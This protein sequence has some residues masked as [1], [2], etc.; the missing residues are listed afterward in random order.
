MITPLKHIYLSWRKGRSSR[1]Y[2]VG[3][4][5]GIAEGLAR[6]NYTKSGVEEAKKDGFV[7]YTEFSDLDKTYDRDVI[8]VFAQ[9]LT[10][11]T[12]LSLS[13]T[14]RFWLV[15]PDKAQSDWFILAYTQGLLSTDN[16][17]FLADF[18]PFSGL[19]FVT[20]L[21]GLSHIH[22]PVDLLKIGDTLTWEFDSSNEYD[23]KAVAIYYS[24]EKVGYIKK[25]HCNLFHSWP[26]DKIRLSVHAIEKNGVVKNVFAKVTLL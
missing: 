3:E 19:I 11:P 21:A 22:V 4:I 23:S 2:I 15:P 10:P 20:D 13:S 17:E 5:S 16:F 25:I 7:G 9:R 1:R 26:S 8:S 14:N 6:F 12:R 18:E 24:G